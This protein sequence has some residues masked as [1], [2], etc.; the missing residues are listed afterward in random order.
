MVLM[1]VI[2]L[3]A[4]RMIVIDDYTAGE[5]AG[6]GC[7]CV[8]TLLSG[9]LLAESDVISLSVLTY[10]V[11]RMMGM[12]TDEDFQA[13]RDAYFIYRAIVLDVL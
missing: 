7:G 3:L 13:I 12:K 11:K 8:M 4:V 9:Q 10:V 5:G 1:V 6:R 2:S